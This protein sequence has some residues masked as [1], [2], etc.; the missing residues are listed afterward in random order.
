M[1]MI[2]RSFHIPIQMDFE[3]EA[4]ARDTGQSKS[5]LVRH[6]VTHGLF[7][8]VSP[9]RPRNNRIE[10]LTGLPAKDDGPDKASKPSRPQRATSYSFDLPCLRA[11]SRPARTRGGDIGSWL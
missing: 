10:K 2:L 8:R 9:S 1:S 4:L 11:A 3:L 7:L 6:F 5:H